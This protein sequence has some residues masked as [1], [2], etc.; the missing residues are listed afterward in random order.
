M[1]VVQPYIDTAISKTVNLPESA[2]IEDIEDI[3]ADLRQA[4]DRL[5]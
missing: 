4:L 2:T 1:R 3:I 5:T